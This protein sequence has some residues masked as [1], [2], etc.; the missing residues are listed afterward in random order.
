[1]RLCGPSE[2]DVIDYGSFSSNQ[3]A[4]TSTPSTKSGR[5]L[6]KIHANHNANQE[7]LRSFLGENITCPSVRPSVLCILPSAGREGSKSGSDSQI[8]DDESFFGTGTTPKEIK[9]SRLS[10]ESVL[11]ATKDNCL[12]GRRHVSFRSPRNCVVIPSLLPSRPPVCQSRDDDSGLFDNTI[13]STRPPEITGKV[14]E[15]FEFGLDEPKGDCLRRR[16]RDSPTQ[17]SSRHCVSVPSVHWCMLP[18]PS[19]PIF[20]RSSQTDGKD[21]KALLRNSARAGDTDSMEEQ[22]VS[23]SNSSKSESPFGALSCIAPGVPNAVVANKDMPV[24]HS[25]RMIPGCKLD[26]WKK[27]E[28][29]RERSEAAKSALNYNLYSVLNAYVGDSDAG[30]QEMEHAKEQ[31]LRHLKN[32]Y[33]L[34]GGSEANKKNRRE[35]SKPE[36]QRSSY[37]PDSLFF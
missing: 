13:S 4:A 14:G 23:S 24:E 1:M 11:S 9:E 22:P 19:K 17:S 33:K 7:I 32:S 34:Y 31:M 29:S 27:D 10:D 16:Q 28:C 2:K 3:K 36:E 15:S 21:S 26:E 8:P 20:R 6:E 37:L 25:P 12:R 5:V 30:P 18:L 35:E